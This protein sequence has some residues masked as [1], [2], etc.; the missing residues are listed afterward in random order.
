MPGGDNVSEKTSSYSLRSYPVHVN[1]ALVVSLSVRSGIWKSTGTWARECFSEIQRKRQKGEK[2]ILYPI[3]PLISRLILV[4][5]EDGVKDEEAEQPKHKRRKNG[6]VQYSPPRE[7]VLG[8][9][10]FCGRVVEEIFAVHGFQ[11]TQSR[12]AGI[13]D[14]PTGYGGKRRIAVGQ[15]V[16]GVD[17]RGH[18]GW[19]Q[20]SLDCGRQIWVGEKV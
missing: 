20:R 16:L 10:G 2:T 19:R 18:E 13:H 12:T 4:K 14:Q 5:E 8:F 1:A 3:N 9:L 7:V 11:H 15:A 17:A 6:D